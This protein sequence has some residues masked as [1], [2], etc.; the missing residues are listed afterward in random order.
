M[1]FCCEVKT[2]TKLRAKEAERRA[3]EEAKR[4]A[5]EERLKE[6]RAK[7]AKSNDE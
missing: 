4:A 7:V 5:E 2:Q 1:T 3:K 6:Q